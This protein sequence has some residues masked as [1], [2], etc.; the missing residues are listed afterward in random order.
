MRNILPLRQL[1]QEVGAQLKMDFAFPAIMHSTVFED[2]N[3]A[4]GLATSPRTTIRTLHIATK[5]NFFRKNVGEGKCI[6]IH[7]VDSK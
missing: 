7:R 4:L 5:Y 2:N 1:V 6:M 3:G